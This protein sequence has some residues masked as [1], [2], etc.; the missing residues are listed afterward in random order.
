MTTKEAT[1]KFFFPN[2][3]VRL[4]LRISPTANF[5]AIVT[6]H[7]NIKTYLQKF[8]I[9]QNPKCPCKKG[10]QKVDHVIYSCKLQEQERDILKAAIKIS[11]QWPVSKDKLVLKYYNNF[12]QFTDNIVLNKEKENKLQTINR[13]G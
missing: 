9:I 13:I 2:I 7:G 12:K 10:D 3:E 5:K 1:T 8:K 6:G 11:K 4:Q